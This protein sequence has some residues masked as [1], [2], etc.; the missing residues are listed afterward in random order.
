MLVGDLARRDGDRD[1]VTSSSQFGGEISIESG[2]TARA[3]KLFDA[4]EGFGS[5]D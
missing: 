2:E 4:R 5:Q 3:I 1:G